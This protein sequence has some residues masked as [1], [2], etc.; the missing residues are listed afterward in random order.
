VPA[1]QPPTLTPGE[2]QE[3]QPVPEYRGYAPSQ[4]DGVVTRQKTSTPQGA[5]GGGSTTPVPLTDPTPQTPVKPVPD[6]DAAN[7]R[8]QIPA[9]PSLFDPRDRTASLGVSRAWAVS[10]IVWPDS[11]GPVEARTVTAQLPVQLVRQSQAEV[12]PLTE[13]TDD[14]WRT[15]RP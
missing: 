2:A 15:V 9:T 13:S 1:D 3:I 10:P 7:G 8:K 4:S 11:C 12:Q 14:G 6:L 5:T